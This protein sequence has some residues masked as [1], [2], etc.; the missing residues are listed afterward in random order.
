MEHFL[1]GIAPL[2][3]LYINP[4][5][6]SNKYI[7]SLLSKFTK[8]LT[9][10]VLQG[11]VPLK[12]ILNEKPSFMSWW[13]SAF[14]EVNDY[15][16]DLIPILKGNRYLGIYAITSYIL[17][18]AYLYLPIIKYNLQTNKTTL[19]HENIPLIL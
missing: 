2:R 5:E 19:L 14:N 1:E 8:A 18:N 11:N 7:Y 4:N 15:A 6:K 10:Q 12:Q 17:P 13:R 3:H 9:E 16:H